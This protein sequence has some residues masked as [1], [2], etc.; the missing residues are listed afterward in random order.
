MDLL[1]YYVIYTLQNNAHG[2]KGGTVYKS[3]WFIPRQHAL[4][5][6]EIIY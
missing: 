2:G 5:A 3:N 1:Q 6:A 4:I